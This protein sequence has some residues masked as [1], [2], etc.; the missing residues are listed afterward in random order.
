MRRDA[1]SDRAIRD[2]TGDDSIRKARGYASSEA[3]IGPVAQGDTLKARVQ[4]TA[5]RPYRVWARVAGGRVQE[6]DCSCPV[7]DGGRCKHVAAVLLT[8]RADPDEFTEVEETDANLQARDKPEL[9]A[10]IKQMLRKAPELESLLAAAVPGGKR[11]PRPNPDVYRR[12]AEAALREIPRWEEWA[13]EGAEDELGVIVETGE[14]FEH[15]GDLATAA[16]VYQ[17]VT[18]AVV[19]DGGELLSGDAGEESVPGR[20]AAG[21]LRC[22]DQERDAGRRESLLRSLFDLIVAHF[23]WTDGDE[24]DPLDA[25][26]HLATKAERR[27]LAG[28]ARQYRG[29]RGGY[30]AERLARTL[31]RIDADVLDDD[32]YLKVCRDAGMTREVVAKLLE[33]GR[34]EE[35]VREVGAAKDRFEL[36]AFADQL[37]AGGQG[38]AAEQLVRARAEK[39]E[40]WEKAR[41]L[42][43]L[44]KRAERRG[45]KAEQLRLA[46]AIFAAQPDL[47]GY[48]ELRKLTPKADWPARREAILRRHARD[49]DGS[50]VI[51]IHLDERDVPA[52]LAV[53]AAGHGTYKALAVAKAA[54]ESHPAEGDAIYRAKAERQIEG[55]TRSA[56]HEACGLLKKAGACAVR[57]GRAAEFQGY[58]AGLLEKYRSLPAF[59]DEVG[60]AKLVQA[61]PPAAVRRKRGS[62]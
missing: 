39:A 6:A 50:L 37:A 59:K 13:S 4:G 28:W 18:T 49:R 30:E 34:G 27:T 41:M 40:R 57:A 31:I 62:E 11:N 22:L 51:D 42:D 2:W 32:G 35:A 47:D 10:L 19:D 1:L 48:R 55:R 60:K 25:V 8:F 23:S 14:E 21:L 24:F 16:A 46:E 26:L 5:D 15:S 36:L 54:E 17:G 58:V 12:Q 38:P 3:I 44:K 7:G 56:Y 9:I 43:W 61:V 20:L 29:M 53:L 33:L 45:D 52:A